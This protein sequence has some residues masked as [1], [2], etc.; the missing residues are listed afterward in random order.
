MP[1][2]QI[3]SALQ[4]LHACFL[5]EM[6]R[7]KRQLTFRTGS[8]DTAEDL[9]HDLWLRLRR[10]SKNVVENPRAY[11]SR[12]ADNLAIDEARFRARRQG[13]TDVNTLRDLPDDRS[14]TEQAIIA[15]DKMRRVAAALSDMPERRRVIFLAARLSG[16][17]YASIADRFGISTRTVEN[18]VR[19]A[20]DHFAATL[21]D[22]PD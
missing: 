22:Y 17:R 14:S 20:L 3:T 11:L 19:R 5:R 18:E 2:D 1:K 10:Q 7:L 21:D 8:I 9:L 12:I 13:S 16:E 15:R 4:D 6:P